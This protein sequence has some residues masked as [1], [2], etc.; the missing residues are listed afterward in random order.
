M[1]YVR[2]EPFGRGPAAGGNAA[3]VSA[4]PPL[5]LMP[6]PQ[7][8]K[9]TQSS[10]CDGSEPAAAPARALDDARRGRLHPVLA[11]AVSR[12]AGALLAVSLVL[13]T[14]VACGGGSS[15]KLAVAA[16]APAAQPG[17][18]VAPRAG[19]TPI[20]TDEIPPCFLAGEPQSAPA[21]ERT[22]LFSPPPSRPRPAPAT[23]QPAPNVA[24]IANRA[25]F[26]LYA[27]TPPAAGFVAVQMRM[28]TVPAPAGMDVSLFAVQYR[29]PPR[30][31][32]GFALVQST[33][34]QGA[35]PP[36]D[37][38]DDALDAVR[39]HARLSGA[40]PVPGDPLA[41]PAV[42]L[43]AL[44]CPAHAALT[45]PIDGQPRRADLV[46]WPGAPEVLLLRIEAGATEVVIESSQLSRDA[47]LALP[48]RL[49]ALQ[50]TPSLV[51]G[52]QA[53]FSDTSATQRRAAQAQKP[54]PGH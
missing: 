35:T 27:V 7:P 33:P 9:R 24:A 36:R 14:V 28:S 6:M 46:S 11:G 13:A 20:P 49:A 15:K 17:A 18:G 45:L 1:S 39:L 25:A 31:G 48:P 42:A 5:Y 10:P 19:G 23:P 44:G 4:G 30:S 51:A 16:T 43:A 38:L 41:D 47:L 29:Q 34:G 12:R 32:G 26:L 21:G 50:R 2:R 8:S 3:A 52:L 22:Q 37:D 40:T 53:Q 54:T